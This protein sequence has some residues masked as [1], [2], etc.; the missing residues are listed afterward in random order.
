M[1]FCA[2]FKNNSFSFLNQQLTITSVSIVGH[3]FDLLNCKNDPLH[4]RLLVL[5]PSAQYSKIDHF[6]EFISIFFSKVD[7]GRKIISAVGCLQ[8]IGDPECRCSL[9]SELLVSNDHVQSVFEK[10]EPE[11]IKDEL[12]PTLLDQM[13]LICCYCKLVIYNETFLI[14]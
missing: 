10:M 5:S 2:L 14:L 6:Y 1:N 11:L 13:Y 8:Y 4:R 12:I 3:L 9:V 7:T